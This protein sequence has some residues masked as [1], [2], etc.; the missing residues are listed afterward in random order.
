MPL[1]EALGGDG[2]MGRYLAEVP[3]VQIVGTMARA[4]LDRLRTPGEGTRMDLR[5]VQLYATALAGRDRSG[6]PTWPSDL[7]D[8]LRTQIT[9]RSLLSAGPT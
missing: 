5:D 1:G 4:G 7:A 2:V 6:W 3:V 9:P 8:C